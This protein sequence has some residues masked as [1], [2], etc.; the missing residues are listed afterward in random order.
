[1]FG[2]LG[3]VGGVPKGVPNMSTKESAE[4]ARKAPY[5]VTWSTFINTVDSME[6]ATLPNRLDGSYLSSMAGGTRPYF[7]AAMKFFGSI[8]EASR[9]EQPLRDIVSADAEGRRKRISDLLAQHYPFGDLATANATA[10][11]LFEAIKSQFGSEGETARKQMSFYLQGC[12]WAGLP[13][14]PHWPVG[15][16]GA[17]GQTGRRRTNGGTGTA[18]KTRKPKPATDGSAA[19]SAAE[20]RSVTLKS[21]MTLTLTASQPLLALPSEELDKVLKLIKEFDRL[22]GGSGPRSSRVSQ[23]PG[24]S[25][26]GDEMTDPPPVR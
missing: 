8:N 19:G 12:R 4:A 23:A 14:S 20:F 3:G 2:G 15:K 24:S 26:G 1:M 11:E 5:N 9:T 13:L 10:D 18:V 16:P 21:G 17:G 25:G 22:P 6:P 7:I